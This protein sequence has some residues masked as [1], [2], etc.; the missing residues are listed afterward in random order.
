M[1]KKRKFL[2]ALLSTA[3]MTAGA[4]GLAA[5]GGG[6]T[7][8][9]NQEYYAAY[10]LYAQAETDAGRT[11]DAYQ[12]WLENMLSEA[13]GQSAYEIWKQSPA[14]QAS[15][16]TEAEWLES[17]KGADGTGVASVALSEDGTKLIITYTDP[18]M[19]AT[20]ID[21][22]STF[23]KHEYGKATV[24]IP[25][26]EQAD[27][28]A[29]VECAFD[30]HIE[31]IKLGK[32]ELKF[33]LPNG[34]PAVGYTVTFGD[35]TATTDADGVALFINDG[36]FKK[37]SIEISSD[38]GQY[39]M[40]PEYTAG[41]QTEYE[42]TLSQIITG[43]EPVSKAGKY[44]V[45]MNYRSRDNDLL[46]VEFAADGQNTHFAIAVDESLGQWYAEDYGLDLTK[47]EGYTHE[48]NV[49]D[50]LTETVRFYNEN[51][52]FYITVTATEGPAT[53]TKELPARLA[54]AENSLTITTEVVTGTK[55]AY[56][57]LPSN[58]ET[59]KFT[60]TFGEG[61]KVYY[62]GFGD[63]AYNMMMSGDSPN[64]VASAYPVSGSTT[65]THYLLV[66]TTAADGAADVKIE[67]Y[68]DLGTEHNPVTLTNGKNSND[69]ATAL[70][71]NLN[72][73]YFKYEC[74]EST[75]YALVFTNCYPFAGYADE[76]DDFHSMYFDDSRVAIDLE[77][78]HTYYLSVNP[79]E[80]LYDI[81]VEK[82]DASKHSG[83][84]EDDPR[85]FTATENTATIN[86]ANAADAMYFKT[87][88]APAGAVWQVTVTDNSGNP[89]DCTVSFWEKKDGDFW[90]SETDAFS[91]TPAGYIKVE[92]W[93]T[94]YTVN[95]TFV[96]NAAKDHTFTVKDEEGNAIS[97]ATVTAGYVTNA[98]E[99]NEEFHELATGTTNASGAATLNFASRDYEIRVS[100][101]DNTTYRVVP[102]TVNY[103]DDAV[104]LDLTAETAKE[105][106]FT[107]A[108]ADGTKVDGM[109]VALY[110]DVY[111]EY[112]GKY[113]PQFVI[114]GTTDA[115]G[116]V[117]LNAF[118]S[119]A[120]GYYVK[121]E[122]TDDY[123]AALT[124]D[125]D[126]YAYS[127]TANAKVTYSVTLTDE[128]GSKLADVV[129][130]ITDSEG[131][132][133]TA[134]TD[135]DGVATMETKLIPG[136]YAIKATGYSVT[137]K[138]SAT[139]TEVTATA[140]PMTYLHF[141]NGS[142]FTVTTEDEAEYYQAENA[143]SIT[144]D[145]YYSNGYSQLTVEVNGE[146]VAEDVDASY[147]PLVIEVD[148]GA[149]IKVWSSYPM[150]DYSTFDISV[151]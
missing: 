145:G 71:E 31:L 89:V 48:F 66:T 33:T 80:G 114:S 46:A 128:S 28:L 27:G 60:L 23:H 40:L 10:Q 129:V 148:A 109:T 22:G 116:V 11:P 17:L 6:E 36:S 93:T 151:E 127:V 24:L 90:Y 139:A 84:T 76:I 61:V 26:T 92:S 15:N 65:Y 118:A 101:T 112:N 5:C 91:I 38:D 69:A 34:D 59:N 104:T 108:A 119:L 82:Y 21:I 49:S 70:D 19:P 97:D 68:Y 42:F 117:K 79:V 126:T 7:A 132:K 1:S 149:I 81:A 35:E 43:E 86:V 96:E 62:Y 113:E 87:E 141:E 75:K 140:G 85:M 146:L 124:F 78:G 107:V 32:Y 133:A 14:G 64:E 138:T 45:D 30:G 99:W 25:S 150:E 4:F 110:E 134:T 74:T 131:T 39:G 16:M 115:D 47:P 95:V 130:T 122:S 50:G 72:Y 135:A 120:D 105:Y 58:D 54:W 142:R 123:Y 106:T 52:L 55:S 12:T 73:A 111:N 94:E 3:V 125:K 121:V 100:F 29:Y 102:V 13:K 18:D 37:T 53:G 88:S 57:V 63:K 144:F 41:I 2:V 137:I 8:T 147:D 51:I 56:C 136:E 67:A 98:G 9:P 44:I 20:E 77:A 103:A 83:Y 143:C